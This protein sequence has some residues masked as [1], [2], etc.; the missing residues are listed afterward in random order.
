MVS[1][2]SDSGWVPNFGNNLGLIFSDRAKKL[3]VKDFAT[4]VK[5]FFTLISIIK[6]NH[7]KNTST[8]TKV[9]IS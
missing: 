3:F 9:R 4:F 7:Y 5:I 2:G 1:F 8:Q 6:K